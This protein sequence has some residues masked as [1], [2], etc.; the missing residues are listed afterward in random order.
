VLAIALVIISLVITPSLTLPLSP[1][2]SP[3]YKIATSVNPDLANEVGWPGFVNTVGEVVASIPAAEP[4]RTVVLAESYHQAGALELLRPAN[5]VRFP[6]IYSG[7]NGFWYWGP[8]PDSATD[9]VVIGDFSPELL[10][11]SYAHCEV[12]AAVATPPGV[13]NDLTGIP[14]RWCTGRLQSWSVLWPEFQLLA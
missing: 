5:D 1:I 13:S 10:S 2:G 12:R 4:G 7:H 9:A 14:I 6:A 8:P 3:L 11:G